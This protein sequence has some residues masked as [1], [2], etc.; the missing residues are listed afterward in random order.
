MFEVHIKINCPHCQSSKIVKN[1]KKKNGAQ[2]LLCRACGK[3]FQ[4][5]YQYKGADP[6]VKQ[7][8]LRLLERNNGIRDIEQILGISRNCV[9]K[10]LL[11]QGNEIQIKPWFKHY[12]S[13]QIDEVWSYVG[14]RKKGKYWLLYA[15]CPE[16]DE[17]L[18][19]VCGSR[20]AKTVRA[21]M[22]KLQG[23]EIEEFCTD[24]WKAFAQVLPE[25]KHKI[26]KAYTKNIE[27]VN[28]CIRAR[29]RRFVRKTTCFSKKKENH[30]AAL[31]IMFNYRNNHK[32]KHHTF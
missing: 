21:L 28:T 26:G 12:K 30:L 25:E 1:G 15:Y 11:D 16:S 2:N 19:Y 32:A 18:A 9:L 24:H 13:V 6:G 14:R 17:I 7:T 29:N 10:T 27:G 23:I 20:S 5:V 3:Q 8:I 4:P 22:K 31:N